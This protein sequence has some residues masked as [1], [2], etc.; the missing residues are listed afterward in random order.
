MF[1]KIFSSNTIYEAAPAVP[2]LLFYGIPALLIICVICGVTIFIK[3][4]VS[5][6]KNRRKGTEKS[7]PEK[8]D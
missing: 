7:H 3:L 8:E 6:L 5:A 2:F 4:L 1:K